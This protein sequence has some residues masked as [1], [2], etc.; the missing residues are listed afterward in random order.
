M[1]EDDDDFNIEEDKA[2]GIKE[3]SVFTI[4]FTDFCDDGSEEVS[5]V[6][7]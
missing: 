5:N 3:R 4:L 6:S 1:V 7:E 2:F